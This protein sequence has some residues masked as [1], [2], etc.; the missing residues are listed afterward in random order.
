MIAPFIIGNLKVAVRA[1]DPLRAGVT[2]NSEARPALT[3]E[4]EKVLVKQVLDP[5]LGVKGGTGKEDP[6]SIN[7][8][9]AAEEWFLTPKVVYQHGAN[10][11]SFNFKAVHA[12]SLADRSIQRR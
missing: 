12:K 9:I 10:F 1:G 4:F 3:E 8:A 6:V 11:I 5:R 7:V 2:T